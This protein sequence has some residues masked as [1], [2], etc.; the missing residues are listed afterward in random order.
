MEEYRVK[1]LMVS[2]SE[3]ATVSE[4]DTLLEAVVA[5]ERA[6]ENFD[7]SRYHHRA[8][9]VRGQDGKIV[10]KLSQLD[11]LKGLEP[12][13]QDLDNHKGMTSYGFSQ[14]FIELSF[15]QCSLWDTP[16]EQVCQKAAHRRVKEFMYSPTEG[17]CVT[18][19]TS[20]DTA[21]HQLIVGRHQSLLVTDDS[22]ETLTGILRLTDVFL[23]LFQII[24]ECALDQS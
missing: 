19:E 16:L 21:I 20:L 6:Q 24:K 14:H 22:G 4:D 15:E 12:K 10:G 11:V 8:I 1:D 9:L 17:E 7:H 5:L 2:L 18:E 3:Y 13:Y 23:G